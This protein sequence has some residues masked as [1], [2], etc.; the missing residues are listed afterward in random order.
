MNP[1][2][3]RFLRALIKSRAG[4]IGMVLLLAFLG[5]ALAAP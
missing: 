2:R 3:S 4:L 1:F 5:A